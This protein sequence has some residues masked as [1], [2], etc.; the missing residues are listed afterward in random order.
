MQPGSFSV[1]EPLTAQALTSLQEQASILLYFSFVTLTTLGF[2][3]ITPLTSAA[4]SLCWLEAVVGQMFIAIL[5]ARLVGLQILSA[6]MD[7][8]G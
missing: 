7:R 1:A 3:D 8:D 2:G 4:R 6:S 5:V